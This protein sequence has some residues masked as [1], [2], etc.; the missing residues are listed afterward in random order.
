[1]AASVT[2]PF[3]HTLSA[4]ASLL[5]QASSSST[6]LKPIA[7]TPESPV[8]A[9]SPAPAPA[10]SG[11][12]LPDKPVRAKKAADGIWADIVKYNHEQAVSSGW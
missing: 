1:M 9:P 10:G 3:P 7:E 11:F 8:A 12:A 4:C 6:P 2:I 5:L